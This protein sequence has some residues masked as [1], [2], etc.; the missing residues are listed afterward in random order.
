MQNVLV[1]GLPR[2]WEK[3]LNSTETTVACSLMIYMTFFRTIFKWQ[4]TDI[5]VLYT[6]SYFK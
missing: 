6:L 4:K 1:E 2:P 5:E 3:F